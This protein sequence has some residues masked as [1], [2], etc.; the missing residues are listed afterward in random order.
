MDVKVRE[1]GNGEYQE[2]RLEGLSYD[3]SYLVSVV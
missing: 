2:G 3:F 1:G